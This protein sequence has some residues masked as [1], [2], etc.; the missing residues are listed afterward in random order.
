[1]RN[2]EIMHSTI[3]DYIIIDEVSMMKEYFYYLLL[4]IMRLYQHVKFIV[5]GHFNQY[6][7][8]LDRVGNKSKAYYSES[9]AFHELCNSNKLELSKC[10]RSEEKQF[11]LVQ[12]YKNVVVSDCYN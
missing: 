1:M 8:V 2:K 6:K 10:R 11:N 4:L 5:C 12:N 9:N 7:P 3:K